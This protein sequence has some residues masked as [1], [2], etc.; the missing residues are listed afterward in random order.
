MAALPMAVPTI[1]SE[2][3]SGVRSAAVAAGAAATASSNTSA[4][5][6]ASGC[7]ACR[8]AV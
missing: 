5:S 7:A 4:V 3:D 2:S 8:L 1:A 6:A